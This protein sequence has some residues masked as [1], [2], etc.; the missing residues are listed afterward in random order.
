MS[1]DHRYTALDHHAA[2]SAPPAPPPLARLR[3]L[4]ASPSSTARSRRTLAIAATSIGILII[5]AA[6]LHGGRAQDFAAG[7]AARRGRHGAGRAYEGMLETVLRYGEPQTELKKQ[8]GDAR[9]LTGMLFGGQSNQLLALINLLFIGK[10][11]GRAVIVP[12]LTGIHFGAGQHRPFH[13]VYDLPRFYSLTNIPTVPLSSFKTPGGPGNVDERVTCWSLMEK[14]TGAPNVHAVETGFEEHKIFTDF[15]AVPPFPRSSEGAVLEF[16]PVVDF[17]SNT[18]AQL[19]WVAT[20]RREYLPQKSVPKGVEPSTVVAEDNVKPFFDPVHGVP[21]TED[22]QLMCLDATFYVGD[23][24]PPPPYPQHVPL[25]PWRVG[26][27]WKEVGQHLHWLPEVEEHANDYLKALFSVKRAKDIPPYISVHVRRGD[28]KAFHGNTYTPL[29]SYVS[30][31]AD[32]RTQ[33]QARLDR[34]SSPTSLSDKPS[35]RAFPIPP[36]EY[37]VVV[38]TDEP[39]GSDLYVE[40]AELGWHVVDHDAQRTVE[41]LGEWYPAMLDGE[42]LSRGQGFVGTQWSTFSMLSG[43]RVEYWQGGVQVVANPR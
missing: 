23:S 19:E 34:P 6:A 42:I 8:M 21:P 30:A 37:A 27:A 28:F 20:T 25:D 16:G 2:A 17:L 32:V 7:F 5:V 43:N 33:L 15:W 1:G 38:T 41:R 39:P 10:E 12:P 22:D 24:V 9:F 36:A 29:S 13:L 35:L 4:I 14:Y 31:V 40:L 26:R 11:L 3:N 18:T